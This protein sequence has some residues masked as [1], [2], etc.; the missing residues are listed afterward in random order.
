MGRPSP[1][2]TIHQSRYSESALEAILRDVIDRI[3]FTYKIELFW[4]AG[5]GC[6]TVQ[7]ALKILIT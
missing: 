3:F 1:L 7:M 4:K 5:N 2:T 6:N